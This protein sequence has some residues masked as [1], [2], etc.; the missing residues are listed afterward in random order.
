L[1]KLLPYK[2]WGPVIMHHRVRSHCNGRTS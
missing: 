2:L 1:T